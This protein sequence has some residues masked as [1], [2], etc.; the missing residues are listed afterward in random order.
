MMF[1]LPTTRRARGLAASLAGLMLAGSA[2]VPGA[3]AAAETG[4]PVSAPAA[5]D[6]GSR[7]TVA[8]LP[9]TQFY[10]RYSAS[11][12]YPRYGTDPFKVQTEWIVENDEAL[13]TAF[14]LHL[15]DVVDQQGVAAEWTAADSAIGVL[16]E[17]GAPFSILPGNHDV[18]DMGARS[19]TANA[20]NYLTHFPESRLADG[21]GLVA[22]H[23]NGYSSAYTF[24]AEGQEFLV[25]ALG[26][27]ASPDTWD[28]AQQ[29]IDAHPTLPVILTSH[30]IIDADK[31]TGEAADFWFGQ[32]MW[33]ELIRTNDQIFITL[34]GHF[35]GQTRRVL[36]N[37]AGHEV[38]Q[39]LLD[40]QMA[41]DGGNG[42]MGMMEFDLDAGTLD[43]ATISPWVGVKH[44]D[45][46]TPSDTPVLTGEQA[47]FT[48]DI[49]FAERFSG[50]APGFGPGD[51]EQAD[52]SEL[53]KEIV[54][55]G[56]T[57][58]DGTD[59]PVAAG[60]RADYV[61]VEGTLAHWRF[62]DLEQGVFP[63]GGEVTDETGANPMHRL[64]LDQ[65]NAPAEVDDVTVTH[66][67]VSTLSADMGAMCF[68]DASRQ[69]GSL[70]YITT[71]YEVPVTKA[72]FEDGYTIESFVYLSPEWNVA[73][74]QWGGW[75]TRTGRRSTLPI[76]WEQ[77]DYQM[78]PAFFS[79]S[80]LREFQWGT[81]QGTPWRNTT[82]LWSGEIMQAN[83]YHVAVVNDPEAHT[84]IMYV[85]G[86]PVLRNANNHDGMTFNDGY[87]WAIGTNWNYDEA[88]N[89]WNGCV[90]ET[91]IVDHALDTSEFL[92]NRADID[93][94][95]ANFH[96]DNA[97]TGELAA[98]AVV[99][100]LAG[101]GFPGA[102][103]RVEDAEGAPLG[104]T[105]VGEDGSWAVEFDTALAG[106]G[107]YT[108]T[109]TQAL[110]TRDGAPT[111]VAFTIADVPDPEPV[112]F[113]DVS[114]DEDSPLYSEHH[115]AI[116]WMAA[117]GISLGW[118]TAD[119]RE[120]RPLARAGRDAL[121]AFL[122]RAAGSPAVADEDAALAGFSDVSADPASP[123]YSE[124]HLAIAWMVE[125]GLT[126]G[127]ADGTFRPTARVTR[128][129]VAAFLHR[130]LGSPEVSD[131][132]AAL[133]RF[134]DVSADPASPRYSE[135]HEAIAWMSE[136]EV[137]TGWSDGTFRPRSQVTRDAIAAFLMRT[138]GA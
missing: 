13:N 3:F 83:W 45:A 131:A 28:W 37:D 55:E 54:S 106:A 112:S 49:D 132:D 105:T 86:V 14:T 69:T 27:L 137:S 87:P 119:G 59:G 62:G 123:H 130:S 96:L 103:V 68:A 7:F 80:N 21:N 36:V 121:A 20:A 60:S 42:I 67:N 6:T 95:G 12:F 115:S 26:W 38:H 35:H 108:L 72:A 52:L 71:D 33:E 61:E 102:Q 85:D 23:Q 109:V 44:E 29:V 84:T 40:T 126:T 92:I 17:G 110:G 65:I 39:L 82:S 77:Y 24:E 18:A 64:P 34:N 1:T 19:S 133:A 98:D 25:L 93:A 9:D 47:D 124:H 41:A 127:W 58:G 2:A 100:S 16:E 129:A 135:H 94:D 99:E 46:L 15:G 90:G 66:D 118:E 88:N 51:G 11:Q 70:N 134:T 53:A 76:S 63:E 136:A 117:Q 81:S 111:T 48:L 91:R 122:Y 30:A 57:G 97:P 120:F 50:F 125:D 128:D 32:E 104:E 138:Y 116:A 107:D 22:A 79:V 114:A 101:D 43:F 31:A 113:G 73:D 56:W 10:S 75:L 5:A 4:E 89:G 8:V 78:G 74:N